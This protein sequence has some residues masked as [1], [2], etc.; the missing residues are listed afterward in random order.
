MQADEGDQFADAQRAV[1]D[2]HRTGDQHRG[3]GQ[4]GNQVEL[5][6]GTGQQ[7]TL[8]GRG[9]VQ[10]TAAGAEPPGHLRAPAERLD[11]ADALRGLLDQGGQVALLV[12]EPPGRQQIGPGEPATRQEQ[13]YR[14]GRDQQPQARV[15]RD[16]QGHHGE[17]GGDVHDEEEQPEGE[18][19]PDHRQ[20]A[21]DPGQ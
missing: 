2:G 10:R 18:E 19:A 8:A 11:G 14:A 13:R 3:Q 7:P 17:V 20:V 12:L 16:Q 15:Q 6:G 21:G 4:V 5:R 1:R 9:V